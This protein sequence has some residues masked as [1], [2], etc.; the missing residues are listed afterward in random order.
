MNILMAQTTRDTSFGFVFVV[1]ALLM[2]SSHR[3]NLKR[4]ENI[5]YLLEIK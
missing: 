4:I 5:S 2:A 3:Q 1:V